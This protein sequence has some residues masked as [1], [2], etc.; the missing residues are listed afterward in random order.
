MKSEEEVI[1]RKALIA[2]LL[3]TLFISPLSAKEL[4]GTLEQIGKSG[5]VRIGYRQSQPPMSFVGE[6]GVP[7][8]YSIDICG[9][10]VSALEKTIGRDVKIEYVPVTADDRFVALTESR[11][12]LLCAA[13]TKTLSRGEI[14]DFTQL[15]FVTGAS[16]MTLKGT[17]L[18]GNFDGK[19]IGV[20]KSTTTAD[21]L[22][23][24]LAEAQ[25]KTDIILFNTSAEGLDAL[26]AGNVDAFSSDQIVLIG[27]ALAEKSPEDFVVLQDL[28]SYEPF[29]LAV[30]RNDADF[31]LV[32]DR[33]ISELYRSK[34]ILK[35]YDKWLGMFSG[36]R[37]S[38]FEALVQLNAIPE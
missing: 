21:A 25:T 29:A 38:A 19:K 24:F 17:E 8:G 13:T 4:T 18:R 14:V 10:I 1:V 35:I 30:R 32:A 23:N 7:A 20:V 28:F 37:T 11:I 5:K 16:F 34:N 36:R 26:K 27:L 2:F 9:E 31:R 6:D 3:S 22:K 15:T 12:D 33:V